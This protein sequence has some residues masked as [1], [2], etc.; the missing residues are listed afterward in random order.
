M[1]LAD[2]EVN[3]NAAMGEWRL[4]RREFVEW[5]AM[6][7][8]KAGR[9]LTKDG[10]VAAMRS[11]KYT[12]KFGQ[13]ELSLA[14]GNHAKPQAVAIDQIKNNQWIRITPVLTKLK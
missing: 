6:G 4:S 11:I 5:T 10:F 2:G 14:N 12:D 1:F 3:V 9:N 8:E 13:P 7:L